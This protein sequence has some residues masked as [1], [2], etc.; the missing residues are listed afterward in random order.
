MT[1]AIFT[2]GSVACGRITLSFPVPLFPTRCPLAR[3][4]RYSTHDFAYLCDMGA[5][6]GTPWGH[7]KSMQTPHRGRFVKPTQGVGTDDMEE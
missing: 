5:H 6:T 7:G 2:R 1:G 4:R 3:G